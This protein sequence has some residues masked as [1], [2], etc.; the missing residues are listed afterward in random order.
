MTGK[1][2]TIAGI[3]LALSLVVGWSSYCHKSEYGIDCEHSNAQFDTSL[4]V[5][6]P[7]NRCAVGTKQDVSWA[8]WLSGN[9]QGIQFHFLDLLELLSRQADNSTDHIPAN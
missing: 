5:S 8:S 2:R 1:I 6:H 7:Q 4:P 3:A 9:G